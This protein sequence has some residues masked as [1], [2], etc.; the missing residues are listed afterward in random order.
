MTIYR[1]LA[2]AAGS[3]TLAGLALGLPAQAEDNKFESGAGLETVAAE[4]ET[5]APTVDVDA[6]EAELDAEQDAAIEAA[7][8]DAVT[9]ETTEATDLT[10]EETTEATDLVEDETTVEMTTEEALEP[11]VEPNPR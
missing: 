3:L 2:L 4:T 5:V 8:P 6:I 11:T 10:T 9:E 7:T 1:K